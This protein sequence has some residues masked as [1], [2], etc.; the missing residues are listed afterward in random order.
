[1]SAILFGSV[2][3]YQQKIFI[4][5]D[6]VDVSFKDNQILVS[7]NGKSNETILVQNS[8]LDSKYM[9]DAIKLQ[10]SYI[11]GGGDIATVSSLI[12]ETF[13]LMIPWD[14][15]TSK[16]SKEN[17]KVLITLTSKGSILQ[18][19][20]A[21]KSSTKDTWLDFKFDFKGK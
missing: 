2:K 21:G 4:N 12:G 16:P 18:V 7:V 3:E 5:D 1:M 19:P 10:F 15:L 11:N 17:A 9:T 14:Q 6:V 13:E 20:L 8:Q